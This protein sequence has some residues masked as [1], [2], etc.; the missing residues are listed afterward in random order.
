[1]AQ[2]V[3]TSPRLPVFSERRFMHTPLL[4]TLVLGSLIAVLAAC[5]SVD[6]PT[7]TD[8][9]LETSQ[10]DPGAFANGVEGP[11]SDRPGRAGVCFYSL[12]NFQGRSLCYRQSRPGLAPSG[13]SL[14]VAGIRASW[15]DR[16]S[17]LIVSREWDVITYA[18]GGFRGRAVRAGDANFERRVARI[19]L[20]NAMSSFR[21]IK[22]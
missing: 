20:D 7:A 18:D 2:K 9:M 14:S 15:N 6:A 3:T 10:N 16:A 19:T 12:P 13:T 21:L 22:Q 8:E 1:M 5:S 4:K 17:S 11:A